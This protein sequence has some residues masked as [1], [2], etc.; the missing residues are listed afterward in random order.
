VALVE[1]PGRIEIALGRS[2]RGV[3]VWDDWTGDDVFAARVDARRLL[4]RR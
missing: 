1:L 4:R 3:V 2:G